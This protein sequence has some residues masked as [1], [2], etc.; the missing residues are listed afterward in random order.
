MSD[1]KESIKTEALRLGFSSCGMT[2]NDSLEALRPYYE[3]FIRRQGHAGM[4]YLETFLEKRM[5]PELVLE[6]TKSVIALSVNYFP[7]EIIPEADNFILSKYAYGADYH[8]VVRD[9]LRELVNFMK[10]AGGNI[11]VKAFV[12]SGPVLEKA[13]AQKCGIGWQGKNTL[14]INKSAGSFF[15]IGII[16][17]DLELEPDVPETDRCGTCNNCITACPTGAL[18]TPYQLDIPRCISYLTIEMREEIPVGLK[19]KLNNRIYGCDICQDVCP[20]NRFARPHQTPEFLPSQTLVNMRKRDWI[21][22]TERD[23]D[24]LFAGSAV[25]RLGYQRFRRGF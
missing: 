3:D 4:G 23:F 22:M 11:R 15:F 12:D 7:P 14:I 18:R 24:G 25:K 9:R 5:H 17:T 2:Y 8:T 19:T 20:Y 13:W 1:L 6:G 10:H 16:L 21:A